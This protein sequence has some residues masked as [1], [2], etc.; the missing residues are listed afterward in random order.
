MR[1]IRMGFTKKRNYEIA[2]AKRRNDAGPR[3]VAKRQNCHCGRCLGDFRDIAIVNR[4]FGD[5]M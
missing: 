4:I 1:M 3:V 2:H 5:P